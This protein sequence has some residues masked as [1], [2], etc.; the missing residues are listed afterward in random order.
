[1]DVVPL[2]DSV[3]INLVKKA[4]EIIALIESSKWGK[5]SMTTLFKTSEIHTIITDGEV[6]KSLL[7]DVIE[8]YATDVI[9]V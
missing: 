8:K 6:P 7:E 9:Q 1:M 5:I 3:R 2:E 4:R